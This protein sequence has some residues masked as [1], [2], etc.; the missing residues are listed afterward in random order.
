MT[1]SSPPAA[2]ITSAPPPPSI[3]SLP[4]PPVI[5]SAAEEPVIVTPVISADASTFW[6]FETLVE[7]PLVWSAL[8]RLTFA[9][10]RNS[11]V[12]VPAPPS[13]DTSDP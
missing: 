12:L 13:I 2:L 5:V 1:V 11:S 8:A 4:A 10:A 3:V 7:S 9:V 6:K